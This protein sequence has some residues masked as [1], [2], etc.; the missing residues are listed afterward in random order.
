MA[1]SEDDEPPVA[2]TA[3][4]PGADAFAE[5]ESVKDKVAKGVKRI[6]ASKALAGKP[7]PTP[8]LEE[9]G[10]PP[11]DMAKVGAFFVKESGTNADVIFIPD[12][13]RLGMIQLQELTEKTW[14]MKGPNVMVSCDAGTVHPKKF[15]ALPLVQTTKSFDGFWKDALQH[16]HR[17]LDPAKTG[18]AAPTQDEVDAFGLAVINDVLFLK[19]VTIFSSIL[20]SAVIAENWLL[21][22]RTGAKSPAADVLLEAS[23]IATTSR[24]QTMVIDSLKR[25]K[26]FR[27]EAGDEPLHPKTQEC[28]DKLKQI[29][30]GA[31]PFGTD[32]EPSTVVISQFYDPNDFMFPDN[33]NDLPLP[34]PA[35]A[36]HLK[37]RSD[38]KPPERVRWQYHYLQTFFGAGT[39]YMVL[40]NPSDCPDLSC[41]G[42]IGYVVANGQGL[43]APRLKTR[44]GAGESIVMLHNTGGVVQAWAS[45]RKAILGSFPPPDSTELME[46]LELKS[47]ADWTRDF[48]LAEIMMLQELH[49][50]APMLLRTS[51]VAVDVMRDTSEDVLSTLTC[52]FAG[53]GGV[54][55][56]GLGEAEQLCVLTCWKRHMI[57]RENADKFEKIADNIQIFLYMLGIVTTALAVFYSQEA[58]ARD[59]QAALSALPTVDNIL[60]AE[61]TAGGLAATGP[62]LTQA[63]EAGS[64]PPVDLSQETPLGYI[65]ILAPIL[66]TFV[67]TIRT[68]MR[69][70]E[71]WST[72]L[73]ASNQIVDQIYRYRLR[74]APYD[75][76]KN[77]P[78]KEG[79]EPVE[80]SPK[81]REMN[82]R[83]VCMA[84]IFALVKPRMLL[85]PCSPTYVSAPLHMAGL[86]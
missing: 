51:C 35:E 27:G 19:L 34:R 66:A 3:P 24:P 79:E 1:D 25:L 4:T 31:V 37:G 10:E 18:K 83:K 23:M 48:G 39:H 36:E 54:P 17:A 15:A 43:M 67:G 75:T 41:L 14:K 42:R 56:L 46:K 81:M 85:Y 44:I 6:S 68:K 21:I 55:E 65:M 63:A 9:P 57:L 49:Q 61:Q 69:P 16:T 45:L 82:A 30:G 5:L 73:M 2:D 62:D 33:Y 20:D 26:I 13:I 78:T 40:D 29:K 11:D 70:R 7:L 80:V 64:G 76:S 8:R 60:A 84:S 50:R 52:C 38:G 53:G 22:D 32:Q 59:Q 12:G 47:T 77:P 72:C 86:H 71:K 58:Q 28:V 74:T